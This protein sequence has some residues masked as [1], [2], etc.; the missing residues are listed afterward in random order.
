MEIGDLMI[1][2][3]RVVTFLIVM[4]AFAGFWFAGTQRRTEVPVSVR[5]SAVEQVIP[6]DGSPVAVRQ[7]RIGIDL[8][9]GHRAVLI[10][11]G[12]EIPEDELDRNEP[13]NQ[14][15]FQPGAGKSIEELEAGPVTV[16]ALIW[17]EL[18]R[19]TR[20]DARAFTWSFRVA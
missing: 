8:T 12:L 6:A 13:L 9:L 4:L 10:I 7:A 20:E 2:T 5:D 3:R 18:D 11:N 16:T 14:V 1:T 15:F 19:E 17:N